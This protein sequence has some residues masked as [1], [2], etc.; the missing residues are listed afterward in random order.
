MLRYKPPLLL[1]RTA[2]CDARIRGFDVPRG[3]I[4]LANNYALTSSDSFWRDPKIFRPERFLREESHV[5]MRSPSGGVE[6]C[7]FIPFS[8]GKRACPGSR[9][10]QAEMQ[11]VARVLLRELRWRRDATTSS[12][13]LSEA[14]GLT[15]AP[16]VPQRLRFERVRGQK[17]KRRR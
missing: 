8:I 12:V 15:L 5:G 3:T 10:A 2:T 6:G 11:A 7:K 13:D 14:Y 16:S 17:E 9:L 1:P 4:V